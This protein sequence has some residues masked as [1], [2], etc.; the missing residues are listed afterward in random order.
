MSRSVEFQ[1][2]IASQPGSWRFVAKGVVR[3]AGVVIG[4]KAGN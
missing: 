2:A 3:P 1:Y 4:R